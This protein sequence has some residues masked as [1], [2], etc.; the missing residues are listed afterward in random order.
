MAVVSVDRPPLN[1]LDLETLRELDRALASAAREPSLDVVVLRGAGERAFSAGVDV[2]D[3]VKE[4]VPEM[5]ETVHGVIRR[6]WSLPQVT[7]AAVRGLCLGGGCELA[8]ACDLVIAS[9]DS[10]FATPE[11]DVGCYPPV[12]LACFSALIGYRRA[13]EMILTG[14]RF[15]AR[16]AHAMGLVSR[17]YP[18]AEL[19]S[20]LEALLTELLEKSSAVLRITLKG[21][22]ELSQRD[23]SAALRRAEE[24]YRDDLLRTRDVEEGVQAFL[25]KRKPRWTHG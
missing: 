18:P 13:A 9:E 5:L 23:F 8:M 22:R 21:L 3:H 2:R 16:E 7:L 1:V 25:E 17:V 14:R 10:V 11:I 12:A 6:L 15:S 19:G 24:I 20:G 4:K